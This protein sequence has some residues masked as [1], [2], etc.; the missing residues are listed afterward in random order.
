MMNASA[1]TDRSNEI[2]EAAIG[3][4]DLKTCEKENFHFPFYEKT[5]IPN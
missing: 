3:R 2:E 5:T 4:F 1:A